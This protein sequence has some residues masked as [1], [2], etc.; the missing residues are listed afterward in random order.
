MWRTGCQAELRSLADAY[1]VSAAESN[2]MDFKRN[3]REH[4]ESATKT[5]AL[6]KTLMEDVARA[7]QDAQVAVRI[8]GV[9]QPAFHFHLRL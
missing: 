9:R 2:L 4:I 7:R 8:L 1:S 3:L 6:A 5:A